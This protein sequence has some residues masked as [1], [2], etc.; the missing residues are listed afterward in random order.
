VD[1]SPAIARD[2]TI[3]F[4][5]WDRKFY[6]VKPNGATAWSFTTGGQVVS[7][8]AIDA[9]GTIYFGSHDKNFYALSADGK[10]KW[11]FTT[12]GQI[13]SSP[14]IQGDEH[15]IFTSVDGF[16]YSVKLD[17][18]LN[19]KLPTGGITEASP[20]IAPDGMIYVGVNTNLWAVTP[21]GKRKWARDGADEVENSAVTFDDNAVMFVARYG[22]LLAVDSE[23]VLLWTRYLHGHH[24]SSPTLGADGTIY[25]AS[26][27][28]GPHLIALP[29]HR[30][31]GRSPWPKFRGNTR[32]TG[33][34]AD[35]TW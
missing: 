25:V 11:E 32:N 2:G 22:L 20:V 29:Q 1:S 21:D 3:H 35:S 14:A 13:V 26:Q 33:N 18:T 30:K 6:A 8:P 15:V 16:L 24:Y 28:G 27:T 5:S 23:M 10:K 12:G 34:V 9:A 7:S 4:G 17:G 19:W 31:L